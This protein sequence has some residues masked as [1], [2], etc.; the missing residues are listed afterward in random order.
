M[1][2]MKKKFIFLDIDGT[3]LDHKKQV[4]ESTKDAIKK[5]RANGHKVFLCTGRSRVQI[6]ESLWNIGF[7]GMVGSAGAYVEVEGNLLSHVPLEQEKVVQVSEY[8]EELGAIFVLEANEYNYA[9]KES[10]A[11]QR[12]RFK[13]AP[14]E[15]IKC[16]AESVKEYETIEE[17]EGINKILFLTSPVSIDIIR[18]KLG[19]SLTVIQSTFSFNKGTGGEISS[20]ERNKAVGIEEVLRYY[21]ASMQDAVGFGDGDNDFEML[22]S[23]KIGV[24]MGNASA[25]LKKLADFVTKSVDKDGIFYGFESV[26]LI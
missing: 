9:N 12:E 3:I 20:I 1:E 10:A 23:V 19:E 2:N 18:E 13:D 4:P 7:D 24:A 15:V 21:G 14:K 25:K 16:Y 5:A 11:Y 6:P 26:G 8:L 17:V 22:A